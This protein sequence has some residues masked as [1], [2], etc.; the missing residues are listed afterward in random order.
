MLHWEVYEGVCMKID[1]K[2][3]FAALLSRRLADARRARIRCLP[4]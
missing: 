1:F 3:V 2:R 4:H